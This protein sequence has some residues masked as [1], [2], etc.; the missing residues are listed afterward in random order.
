MGNADL[1]PEKTV[2]YEIG[3]QQALTDDWKLEATVYYKDIKNLLGQEIINTR[4]KKF[5]PAT[6]IAITAT[7][8]DSS[9]R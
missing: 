5:M 4:D 7:H 8:V 3:L 6:S 1:K 9:Y 2:V